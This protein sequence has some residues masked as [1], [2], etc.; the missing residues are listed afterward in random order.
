MNGF[1]N[2]QIRCKE[3]GKYGRM[4]IVVGRGWKCKECGSITSFNIPLGLIRGI[5]NG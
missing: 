1:S 4:A 2:Y 3:C 5:G